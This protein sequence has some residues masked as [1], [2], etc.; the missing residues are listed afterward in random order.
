MVVLDSCRYDYF[1]E[2]N[3]I[4]GKLTEINSDSVDTMSWY[5]KHWANK[6]NSDI[7]M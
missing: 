6:D 1:K 2:V 4:K 3:F 5:T 7:L